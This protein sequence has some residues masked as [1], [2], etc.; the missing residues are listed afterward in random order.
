MNVCFKGKFKLTS[1]YG[2]RTLNGVKSFH[3]GY[4][5]V[6]ISDTTVRAPFDGVVK[7]S[8]IVTDKSNLTWQWGNYVRI[9]TQDGYS[10]Y[11]CHLK[12]RNVKKGQTVRK[13]DVIG[14]MGNTGYSFGAHT[15]FEIRKTATNKAVN[16]SELSGIPNKTGTYESEESE[17]L[18]KKLESGNDIVWQLMNRKDKIEITEP[19][20]AIKALDKAKDS[21]EFLPLYWIIYK[22]VNGNG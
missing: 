1:P 17:K 14:I 9:D 2:E 19:Q 18:T 12:S 8:T 13:G 5:L 15:H 6:G 4:D 21:A 16:P 7:T 3:N 20:R 11:L 22:L 10:V